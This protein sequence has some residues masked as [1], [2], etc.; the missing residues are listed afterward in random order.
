[1]QVLTLH[2]QLGRSQRTAIADGITRALAPFAKSDRVQVLFPQIGL[3]HIA[4]EGKLLGEDKPHSA[5][6]GPGRILTPGQM[7][8]DEDLGP[9]I[10]EQLQR[11]DSAPIILVVAVMIIGVLCQKYFFLPQEITFLVS[12]SSFFLGLIVIGMMKSRI[13]ARQKMHANKKK[14]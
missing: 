10:G 1:M 7:K 2:D 14:Q 13:K 5:V 9:S 6:R 3:S 4:I 12:F 11:M 8:Q